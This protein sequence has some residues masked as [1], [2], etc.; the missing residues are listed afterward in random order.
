MGLLTYL[1]QVDDVIA[2]PTVYNDDIIMLYSTV[3]NDDIIML[4]STVYNVWSHSPTYSHL[5]CTM[6]TSSCYIH[7][8]QC[9]MCG[10]IL[11]DAF[12]GFLQLLRRGRGRT[13]SEVVGHVDC[14]GKGRG[15]SKVLSERRLGRELATLSAVD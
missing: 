11:F 15:C 12:Q 8:V 2:P 1:L 13:I 7:V 6:M 4:Y 3:Y 9:I 14:R 5:P 10:A